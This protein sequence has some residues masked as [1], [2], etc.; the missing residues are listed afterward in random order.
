MNGIPTDPRSQLRAHMREQRSA[1][2]AA[3]RIAAA[4]NLALQLETLPELLVDQRIGAYWAV[5]GEISL[6]LVVAQCWRRGQQVLLPVS[7]NQRQL[8]YAAYARDTTVSANRHGIPEPDHSGDTLAAPAALELVFV[9]M[10]AFDRRGH[11]LGYGGGYYDTSF[12]FL[13]G[14]DRPTTPL[15][16]GVAYALQEVERVDAEP[17]DISLDF[18]ATE[19]EL[20]DCNPVAT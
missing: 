3:T 10:L 7:R 20:I 15:L 11:R 17:W 5:R 13:S 4:Q 19:R 8:A 16:V 2:S 12:S 9:P 14:R 1:L 18:I 6:H